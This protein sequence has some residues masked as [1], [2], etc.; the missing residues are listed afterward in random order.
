M[1]L[2]CVLVCLMLSL[3]SVVTPSVSASELRQLSP[4]VHEPPVGGYVFT[5]LAPL[6]RDFRE[7]AL[8]PTPILQESAQTAQT[9][10]VPLPNTRFELKKKP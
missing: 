2:F 8:S 4:I 3:F 9:Q 5:A 10:G 1:R 7:T 6:P